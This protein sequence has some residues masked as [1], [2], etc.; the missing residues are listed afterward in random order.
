[1]G[2]KKSKFL[3]VAEAE[4]IDVSHLICKL[5]V[6]ISFVDLV[7][8][9]KSL[10]VGEGDGDSDGDGDG[11][12]DG[13]CDGERLNKFL[14]GSAVGNVSLICGDFFAGGSDGDS[15]ISNYFYRSLIWIYA[16]QSTDMTMI[17][18]ENEKR[19]E[20]K[21]TLARNNIQFA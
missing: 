20:S 16:W 5:D 11:D 13:D 1:M 3:P 15:S 4:L 6:L 19:N 17:N 12:G 2:E 7:V 14:I 10:W 8:E 18:K 9:G 21:Y